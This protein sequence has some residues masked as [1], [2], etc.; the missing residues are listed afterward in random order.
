MTKKRIPYHVKSGFIAKQFEKPTYC[1]GMKCASIDGGCVWEVT[2]GNN[3][4]TKYIVERAK[5]KEI[6][7][8]YGRHNVVRKRPYPVGDI[9]VL[10][11]EELP[12][13]NSYDD[14]FDF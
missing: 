8:K 2:V 1:I 9:Y 6:M 14:I 5:V 10:P 3:K 7:E 4:D 11:V 12:R 13:E